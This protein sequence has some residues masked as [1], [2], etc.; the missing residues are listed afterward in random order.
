MKKLFVT[1]VA[2][3]MSMPF[4][5]SAARAQTA[6]PTPQLTTAQATQ[7][8]TA[9]CQA[10][11]AP[12]TGSATAVFPA[13]LRY[14]G[15]QD[16]FYLPRWNV[17]FT[18]GGNVQAEVDVVDAS[19]S[20]SRYFNFAL[21]RQQLA[22]SQAAGTPLTQA[23][24]ISNATSYL[25]A[26][27]QSSGLGAAVALGMQM[28]S[29]PTAAG[30]LWM[31]RWTRQY[32]GIPY[33]KQQ[34]TEILQAETGALQAMTVAFPSPPPASGAG[35]VT[36]SQAAATSASQLQTASIPTPVFQASQL[37]IVQPNTFW[38]ANGSVQPQPNCAGV[39]AWNCVYRD[40]NGMIDEVWVDSNTGSIVGGE[41]YGPSKM[42]T[43]TTK[44]QKTP[45]NGV[46]KGARAKAT[47]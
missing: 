12:V 24:A 40:A 13:P 35:S 3:T 37:M 44:S 19:S 32:A 17:K 43:R 23:A 21:S 7:I 4:F 1:L 36:Q 47:K 27:G 6:T 9:F 20:V 11:G 42:L 45:T 38:M 8:A 16:S 5:V 46:A 41:I 2:V 10:V 22:N 25:T 28:T 26:A 29:P 39:V 34:V 30:N 18:T 14:A 15:Q 31:V 33:R